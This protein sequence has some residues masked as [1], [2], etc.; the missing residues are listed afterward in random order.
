MTTALEIVEDALAL[1]LVDEA[2][3]TI[4]PSEL[5]IGT[6]FLNDFCAQLF[7]LGV[8]F[9]YRPVTSSGDPITSPSSV[10]LALKQN[11]GVLIAPIFGL[12][13]PPDLRADAALSMRGLK[14]NFIRRPKARLPSNLPMG[15]GNRSYYHPSFYPFAL[16]VALLRL[17]S[18]STVT[19]AATDT[20]VVVDGWT[21]DRSINVTALAA[22]TVQY[23]ADQPYLALLESS[24][25][26]NAAGSKQ[27][28]AYFR[29]NSAVIEQSRIV[30]D[31]DAA[32][33]ILLKWPEQLRR[34]D[35]VDVAIEN[36]DDTTDLVITSGHFTVT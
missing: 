5:A 16:P 24:L 13:V 28:T 4:D 8:D 12:P 1:V 29:K 18:S 35:I 3:I 6:R 21:V 19:I 22:G 36:N 15:S 10:N 14:A 23:L 30:F 11:L 26:V 17:D 9:G 25:T 2:D 7:D 27:F 33:N 32:Q 34:N 31:A 20:P